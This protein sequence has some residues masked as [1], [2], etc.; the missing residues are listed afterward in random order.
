[1]AFSF[2]KAFLSSFQPPSRKQGGALADYI[3]EL[4]AP[5]ILAAA[6]LLPEDAWLLSD[7]E[8]GNIL[9]ERAAEMGIPVDESKLPPGT[10]IHEIT[11]EPV[12]LREGFLKY[13]QWLFATRSHHVGAM[14]YDGPTETLE[15]I[16]DRGDHW[17]YDPIDL[18][19]AEK[20]ATELLDGSPGTA[21]WDYLRWR[22]S[23]GA[24]DMRSHRQHI[25]A[26][27]IAGPGPD[28]DQRPR[29]DNY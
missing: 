4:P 13:G 22:P 2:V 15:V 6:E 3:K 18:T 26:R 9:R 14:K 12:D 19:L 5:E 1:M 10:T 27:L 8:K 25:N 17:A 23:E 16:Y 24:P 29:R 28:A 20:F 7:E 11:P 21:V